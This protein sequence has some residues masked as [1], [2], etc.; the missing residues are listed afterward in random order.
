MAW[1]TNGE[2]KAAINFPTPGAPVPDSDIDEFI[3]DSQQ[4]IE[5]LYKTKFGH[6]E[7]SGTAT[8]ATSSTFTDS[9]ASFDITV[10]F[11]KMVLWVFTGTDADDF[12]AAT[13]EL[14]EIVSNTGTVITIRGS[15]GV[16][17]SAGATYRVV[18]L[19]FENET[20]DGS[21]SDTQYT[22]HQ[23]L[24]FL[25]ALTV[26]TISITVSSVFTS[27]PAGELLLGVDS[28]TRAFTATNPRLV[29][30]QYIFGFY[31]ASVDG[32]PRSMKRLC[33][34]FAAMRTAMAKVTGS[35]IDF[36]TVALPGISGSKGQPYINLK[37][38]IDELQDEAKKITRKTFRPF[39]L[40][41]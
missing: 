13:D 28:Q 41:G 5:D 4:E 3:K 23:P 37:A 30:I 14:H 8:A 9:T 25:K 10:G 19:G 29:N 35:Y 33:I 32:L 34:I 1:V 21:G 16:T 36:A 6:I 7:A 31:D 27:L 22:L 17:P 26:D 40:F 15:F 20:V 39:T 2:V 38:G 18:D 24:F 11:R 12:P